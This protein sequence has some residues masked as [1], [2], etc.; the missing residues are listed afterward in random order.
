ML[1]S[2]VVVVALIVG[3]VA[4]LTRI[5]GDGPDTIRTGNYDVFQRTATVEAFTVTSPSD[6]YLVNEW[7]LSMLI[8]VE[9]SGGSASACF[10]VPGDEVQECEDT[11]NDVTSSPIPV[12]QGLPMLQLSNVDL[13]LATNACAGGLPGDAAVLYVALDYDAA[14]AGIADPSIPEFPPGI[15]LPPEGD[16]PCGP[17]R[18]A[19]F[20]VNGERFFAWIGVGVRCERRETGKRSRPP[21]R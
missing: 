18:Y 21:T 2:A 7:P 3:S 9:G 14:I 5:L 10:T 4:G 11:P 15:G 8:A 13:G 17:G 20:T 19:H 6:W 12:P 1:G 16:G